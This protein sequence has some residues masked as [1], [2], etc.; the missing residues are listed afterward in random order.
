M[1][2]IIFLSIV[3][4][5]FI[6]G[7]IIAIIINVKNS[8]NLVIIKRYSKLY[9]AIN[10]LNDKYK[11]HNIDKQK[12]YFTPELKSRRG[13]ENFNP[14][15]YMLEEI[16]YHQEYWTSLFNKVD[17]NKTNYNDY[18]LEYKRAEKY[19]TKEEFATF[20]NIKLKYKTFLNAEKKLYKKLKLKK[21]IMDLSANI[22]ATYTSPAGNNHYW[23]DYEYNFSELKQL[24]SALEEKQRMMIIEKEKKDKLAQEKKEK[25][26]R[27]RELDK[28][29]AEIEKR[30]KNLIERE[31]GFIEATKEHIYTEDKLEVSNKTIV[32]DESL[33]LTKKLELLK[34]KFSSGEITYDEYQKQRKE[35]MK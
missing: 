10:S 12:L 1:K 15:Q 4:A 29:E 30:E 27:L 6:I 19:I 11:F 5:T 14:N 33:S 28:K 9:T 20:K 13:L 26:K 24:L 31:K 21:P 23:A 22:H 25:E 2:S 34:E 8:K 3:L 18:L 32:I 7:I 35:L 17:Y 16:E